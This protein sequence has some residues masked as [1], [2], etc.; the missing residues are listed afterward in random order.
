MIHCRAK[1][2]SRLFLFLCILGAFHA[3]LAAETIQQ[4]PNTAL[5]RFGDDLGWAEPTLNESNWLEVQIP[6][7]WTSSV[8]PWL[9]E[10]YGWYRIRFES[11]NLNESER[12]A[13]CI[14]VISDCC[15]VFLNGQLVGKY[16]SMPPRFDGTPKDPVVIEL[17]AEYLIPSQPQLVAVRVFRIQYGGGIM[18][19]PLFVGST[20]QVARALDQ[21]LRPLWYWDGAASAVLTIP[22]IFS[23]FL[24]LTGTRDREYFLLMLGSAAAAALTLLDSRFVLSIIG[25]SHERMLVYVIVLVLLTVS[26]HLFVAEILKVQISKMHLSV[27]VSVGLAVLLLIP[28]AATLQMGAILWLIMWLCINVSWLVWLY[29]AFLHRVPDVWLMASGI[30]CTSVLVFFEAFEIVGST[31][32]MGQPMS[33]F[34]VAVFYTCGLWILALR[35]TRSRDEVRLA[36]TA[37]LTAHEDERRRLAREIHDGVVQ[38]ILAVQLNLQM[39]ASRNAGIPEFD[40]LISEI[41]SANEDLRRLSHD[42]RPEALEKMGLRTAIASHIARVSKQVGIHIMFDGELQGDLHPKLTDNLYRIFQEALQNGIKHSN[43][44]EIR[45]ALRQNNDMVFM[46]IID[47]GRGLAERDDSQPGFGMLTIRERAKLLGGKAEILSNSS[48]GVTV[49]VAIP[50][51]A[52]EE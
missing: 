26:A 4:L 13:I 42:L 19:G 33:Y 6:A 34:G 49:S 14:G 10:S 24:W 18:S 38:S 36:T 52:P 45:V 27:I 51:Q 37:I 8:D 9:S 11:P 46:E 5:F 50:F 3:R 16:G 23:L 25:F 41:R 15:E 22:F 21:T 48:T 17:P 29:Q 47:D 2:L 35:F 28:N 30:L 43:A 44:S 12:A 20:G 32:W 1:P 40:M 7:S 31:L 39:L